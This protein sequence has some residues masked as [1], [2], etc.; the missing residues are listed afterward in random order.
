MPE[1]N[2]AEGY[3]LV[4]PPP[5]LFEVNTEDEAKPGNPDSRG[6]EPRR[7]ASEGNA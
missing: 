2:V 5:G 6:A 3:V 7:P 1:V 4:T